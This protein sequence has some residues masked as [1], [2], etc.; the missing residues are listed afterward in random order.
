MSGHD[1]LGSQRAE[2]A[3]DRILDAATELF[4]Q[5]D[6]STVGMN[7]IARAA[8]CSR[9]TLYR[10][11]DSRDALYRSYVDREANRMYEKMIKLI[12]EIEDPRERFLSAVVQCLELVRQSPALAAWFTPDDSPVGATIADQSMNIQSM[13]AG[14][15]L[16]LGPQDADTIDRRARWVIRVLTSLL[17]LPGQDPADERALI[18]EFVVPLVC[19]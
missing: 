9:A 7:D 11:F 4:V 13:V 14:F 3:S 16:S 2:A 5:H 18:E 17:M 10:Y 12:S 8:G 1:W 15:L 6:V 19:P